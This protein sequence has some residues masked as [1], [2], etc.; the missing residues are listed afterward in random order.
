MSRSFG[1]RV[2][3]CDYGSIDSV[4]CSFYSKSI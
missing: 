2:A 1:L 4:G 3:L